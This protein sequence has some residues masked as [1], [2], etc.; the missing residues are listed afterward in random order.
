M[1]MKSVRDDH[2]RR[3][4][5][6]R[7]KMPSALVFGDEGAIKESLSWLNAVWKWCEEE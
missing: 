6:G 2:K 3:K 7:L 1:S 5:R 4:L